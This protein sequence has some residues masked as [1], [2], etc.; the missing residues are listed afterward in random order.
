MSPRG[1]AV[2]CAPAKLGAASARPPG[3]ARGG[4][5]APSREPGRGAV[6]P[7]KR[8]TLPPAPP[9]PQ[10]RRRRGGTAPTAPR[11][12]GASTASSART[13]A[14]PGSPGPQR[15]GPRGSGSEHHHQRQDTNNTRITT[16]A[17]TQPR[18]A[19]ANTACPPAGGNAT[20]SSAGAPACTEITGA[21]AAPGSPR[22]QRRAP[23][24]AGASTAT[25]ARTPACTEIA[26]TPAAPGSPGPR[27]H[28][29]ARPDQRGGSA[30]SFTCSNRP[31]RTRAVRYVCSGWRR[32]SVGE[33]G[34]S[35]RSPL[36]ATVSHGMWLCPNTS[37]SASG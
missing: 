28:G 19:G 10:Q 36:G 34:L 35:R 30:C 13:P 8:C 22:P 25:S 2:G 31:A 4:R 37:T 15:H 24:A 3:Q 12:A 16:T 11:G 17:A 9:G 26:R 32:R 23:H 33:P 7:A 21:P 5:A 27:R 14:A 18:E 29:S 6:S 1:G 20:A